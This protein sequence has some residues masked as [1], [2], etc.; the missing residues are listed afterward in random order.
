VELGID[1]VPVNVRER[2]SSRD[3]WDVCG[4]VVV[5][6]VV[7]ALPASERVATWIMQVAAMVR[8]RFRKLPPFQFIF[9]CRILVSRPSS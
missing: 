9:I 5:F 2:G 1:A 6:R 8:V 3:G 4:D 7:V